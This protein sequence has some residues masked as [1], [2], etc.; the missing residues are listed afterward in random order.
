MQ[1]RV[2]GAHLPRLDK[3]GIARFI[4][5]D[6]AS[7]KKTLFELINSGAIQRDREEVDERAL[8]L[9]EELDYDLQRC[10]LFEL[11]VTGNNSEFDPS[12]Y[13]N[14]DSDRLGW[15]PVFISID[16]SS[17]IS[18]AYKAPPSL[19]EFRV[20]FYVHDWELPGRLVGPTGE[21]E[22]PAFTAVP[23]RLWKLAPYSCVD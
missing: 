3:A 8:E 23:E 5:E 10:A 21:L 16:G 22:L 14:P 17:I 18:E 20:A 13:G 15:E 19:K 7:F 6:V 9:T 4:E 12:A 2:L 1:V 11:E